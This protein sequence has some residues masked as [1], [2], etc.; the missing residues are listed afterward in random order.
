MY[1]V[2]T[3]HC[4]KME[5]NGKEPFLVLTSGKFLEAMGSEIGTG[6]LFSNNVGIG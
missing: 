6:H 5:M 3:T 1:V 2:G 4:S